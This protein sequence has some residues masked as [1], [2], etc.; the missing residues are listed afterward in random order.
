MQ[1]RGPEL[2]PAVADLVAVPGGADKS[3]VAEREQVA[4]GA[5][6]LSPVSAASAV[7]DRGWSTAVRTSA[8]VRPIS[9]SSVSGGAGGACQSPAMPVAG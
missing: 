7:V 6:G 1:E 4:G 2:G 8:R 9:R 3:R 5:A